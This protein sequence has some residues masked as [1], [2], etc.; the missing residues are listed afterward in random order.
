M[1]I[2]SEKTTGRNLITEVGMKSMGEDL[3]LMDEIILVTSAEVTRWSELKGVPLK[4]E[5]G[6]GGGSEMELS[7]K[8]MDSCNVE[9][10]EVKNCENLEHNSRFSSSVA[11]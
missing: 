8:R 6:N 11:V 7:L 5:S 2:S 4:H 3:A 9:I 10:L 1:L